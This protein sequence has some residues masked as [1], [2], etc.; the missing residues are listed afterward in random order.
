LKN[1]V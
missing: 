1:V